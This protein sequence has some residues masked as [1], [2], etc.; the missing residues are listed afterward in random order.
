MGLQ[1]WPADGE[2]KYVQGVVEARS[3]YQGLRNARTL[4]G[5]LQWAISSFSSLLFS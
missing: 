4:E 3:Y 1:G 2:S 5:G